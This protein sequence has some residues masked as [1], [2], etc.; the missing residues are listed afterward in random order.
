M[1]IDRRRCFSASRPMKSGTHNRDP[2]AL[3]D[4]QWSEAFSAGPCTADPYPTAPCFLPSRLWSGT[5]PQPSSQPHELFRPGPTSGLF[6]ARPLTDFGASGT[7]VCYFK[8]E[9]LDSGHQPLK[10][11]T[12]RRRPRRALYHQ[13]P[14][15]AAAVVGRCSLFQLQSFQ[16][17]RPLR[18]EDLMLR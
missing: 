2:P 8:P 14:G 16:T 12:T 5:A 10:R 9:R 15:R 17:G 3:A 1:T 7:Q 11:T 18:R 4:P 13:A 6:P